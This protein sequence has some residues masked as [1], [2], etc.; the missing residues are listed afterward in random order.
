[1]TNATDLANAWNLLDQ[2]EK[3]ET[4]AR[5][6]T[7]MNASEGGLVLQFMRKQGVAAYIQNSPDNHLG[8]MAITQDQLG[9]M[10]GESFNF[11][12]NDEDNLPY[13]Y[14]MLDVIENKS[15]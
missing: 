5:G 1:M 8:A 3:L 12:D 9:D 7:D 2:E 13:A 15:K 14:R 4:I 11:A 6:L 10:F